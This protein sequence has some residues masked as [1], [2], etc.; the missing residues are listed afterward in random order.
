VSQAAGVLVG[1]AR[2][3]LHFLIHAFVCCPMV[4]R[5]LDRSTTS[6]SSEALVSATSAAAL[7]SAGSSSS[8]APSVY[9]A[10][11][12]KGMIN[13][14]DGCGGLGIGGGAPELVTGGRDGCVRVWDPRVAEAVVSL[15]PAA[16][17]TPRDC[18]GV[19]FGNS[20][21]DSERCIVAGYDNGDV[22]LFDLR[23][24]T[25]RWETNVGNGVV[26]VE[27]DRKDIAMNKLVVT[28]L[29]SKF[30]VFDM[31]TQHPS[32][33]FASHTEKAHKATVWM[34]KH[35][36]QNRDLFMTTGGNGGLNIYK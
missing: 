33:G 10:S 6:K 30:K 9:S 35:V 12:H 8:S 25:M 31:R 34:C 22:K 14:I 21:D 36:P 20:Y 1:D 17:E 23:T 2:R 28:M 7:G 5:D 4:C 24:Q 18:W 26:S 29:E 19:A 27:F 32:E 11:A 15:E 3:R 16:G 13:A